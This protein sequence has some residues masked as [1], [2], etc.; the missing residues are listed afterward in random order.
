MSGGRGKAIFGQQEGAQ[1]EYGDNC[2]RQVPN[3]N[4][5]ADLLS[6]RLP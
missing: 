6:G 2:E 4:L 3:G 1:H 5:A